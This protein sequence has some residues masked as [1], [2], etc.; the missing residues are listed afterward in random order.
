[1]TL[2]RAMGIDATIFCGPMMIDA[3]L[4]NLRGSH[5]DLRRILS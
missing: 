1:M 4:D 3:V 2:V 5:H